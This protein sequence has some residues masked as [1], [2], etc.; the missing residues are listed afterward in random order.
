MSRKLEETFTKM[1]T[2]KGAWM[3]YK[4]V[5][6]IL[7]LSDF[8]YCLMYVVQWQI[9]LTSGCVLTLNGFSCRWIWSKKIVYCATWSRRLHRSLPQYS[10]TWEVSTVH[11]TSPRKS[12]Y[13]TSSLLCKGVWKNAK[14]HMPYL[15]S[16]H[17]SSVTS[18]T[19]GILRKRA[20]LRC[21]QQTGKNILLM[22]I[23]M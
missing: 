18:C 2:L 19:C 6:K 14:S 12:W 4:A 13:Y 20:I 16:K 1:A 11:C 9:W 22:M 23:D 7:K 5:G 8:I 10:C 3:L 17:A 15:F 21:R